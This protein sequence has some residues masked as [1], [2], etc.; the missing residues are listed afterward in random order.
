LYRIV[1]GFYT[2]KESIDKLK[3]ELISKLESIK[4]ENSLVEL[5]GHK[6]YFGDKHGSNHI[7][8]SE[9]HFINGN[10]V[11]LKGLNGFNRW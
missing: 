2:L 8:Y 4:I 9:K 7:G 6:I 1:N 5:K 3:I 11:D 10:G